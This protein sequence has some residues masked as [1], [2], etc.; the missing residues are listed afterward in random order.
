LNAALI[1]SV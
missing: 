1:D